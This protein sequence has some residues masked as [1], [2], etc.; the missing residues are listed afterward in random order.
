MARIS[1]KI[2]SDSFY[3]HEI[4]EELRERGLSWTFQG[5]DNDA[6]TSVLRQLN[7]IRSS[8]IYPHSDDQCSETCAA[9]GLVKMSLFLSRR[10]SIFAFSVYNMNFALSGCNNFISMDGIWKLRFPHCM[11]PVKTTVAG[12]EAL[13]FPD[14]CTNAP[15]GKG[16]AF[17]EDHCRTAAESGV[18]T[19][20]RDF[21]REYCGV[22]DKCGENFL[23]FNYTIMYFS[24]HAA[25]FLQRFY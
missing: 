13:N 6:L 23:P 4:E 16:S 3:Q 14:V 12:F 21:L 9:R 18:P 17:C 8:E 1:R 20:L 15:Y 5:D 25:P 22:S 11:Y 7:E 10:G 19:S 2:V 24:N